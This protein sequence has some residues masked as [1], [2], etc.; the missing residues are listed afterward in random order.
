MTNGNSQYSKSGIHFQGEAQ[1]YLHPSERTTRGQAG[2]VVAIVI[3][4][5]AAAVISALALR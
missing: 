3:V 2:W 1:D 4:L 5:L